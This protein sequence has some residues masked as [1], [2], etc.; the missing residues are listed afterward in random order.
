MTKSITGRL[1][2]EREVFLIFFFFLP[3]LP[4]LPVNRFYCQWPPEA[5]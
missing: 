5:G 4:S 2:E 1:R 3:Y